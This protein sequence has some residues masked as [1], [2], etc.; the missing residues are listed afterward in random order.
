[1]R[2]PIHMRAARRAVEISGGIPALCAYLRVSPMVVSGWIEGLQDVPPDAL[3]KVIDIVLGE[4]SSKPSA[5]IS[6]WAAD[7]FRH[8]HAANN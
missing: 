5:A 3:L 8:R 6:D 7:S 2:N 4:S 1:M